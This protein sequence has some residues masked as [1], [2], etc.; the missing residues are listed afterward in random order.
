[1]AKSLEQAFAERRS[2]FIAL[3]N[4][5]KGALDKFCSDHNF[6]LSGRVKTIDSLRNKIESGRFPD[7]DSIDDVV[8][9]SVII[10]TS[11]QV[12]MVRDYLR[13]SFNICVI[14][15]GGTIRD[16]RLF[17][18][19]C[20]RIY[21]KIKDPSGS[22]GEISPLLFEVQIRTILQHAWAKITHGHVYKPGVFDYRASR[23]ASETM[24]QIEAIDR[25]FSDFDENSRKVKKIARK[26]MSGRL[27]IVRAIDQLVKENIIPEDLRISDGRILGDNI[28][29]S[30]KG[31]DE[32]WQ[33][34]IEEMRKFFEQQRD[35]FPRSVSLFQLSM[36]R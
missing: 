22:K 18:F 3:F 12:K 4:E 11:D 20:P 35:K 15:A 23:L 8:A 29:T 10:D 27:G 21:C 17:D 36:G 31:N 9:F 28:F 7:I 34:A 32:N 30:I 13:K 14:R 19:D 1:M 24:A 25:T 16:E 33:Q 2:Y 26:G 6:L 5:V